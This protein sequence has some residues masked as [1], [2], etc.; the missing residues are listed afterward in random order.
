MTQRLDELLN[1]KMDR[2]DFLK[3]LGVGML[4]LVG[5]GAAMRAL[6]NGVEQAHPQP[7][8][9]IADYYGSGAYGGMRRGK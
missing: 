1:R 6:S 8:S 5:L 4:A 9:Q 3:H 2:R 7:V